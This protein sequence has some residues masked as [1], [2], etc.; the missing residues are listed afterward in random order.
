MRNI[1]IQAKHCTELALNILAW[2]VKAKRV[3]TVDE[4]QQAVSME[5]DRYELDKDDLPE[6]TAL[7]DVLQLCHNR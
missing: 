6:S 5:S 1:R 3:M 7:S 4:L 2:L